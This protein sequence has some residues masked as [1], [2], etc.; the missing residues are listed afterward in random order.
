MDSLPLRSCERDSSWNAM[1]KFNGGAS[2][3]HSRNVKQK[4]THMEI[5]VIIKNRFQT[6]T[7][8]VESVLVDLHHLTQPSQSP[9][10]MEK[11]PEGEK[12][13][14]VHLVLYNIYTI[15]NTTNFTYFS[16]SWNPAV[17]CCNTKQKR[18]IVSRYPPFHPHCHHWSVTFCAY[19]ES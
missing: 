1:F 2:K 10:V 8:L 17:I 14:N 6:I 16:Q 13:V 5:A 12:N 3:A 4:K 9:P 7:S 19:K 11:Q 18:R 15:Y